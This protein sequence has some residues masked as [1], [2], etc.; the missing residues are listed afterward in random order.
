MRIF[1]LVLIVGVVGL[2]AAGFVWLQGGSTPPEARSLDTTTPEAVVRTFV[3]ALNSG[4]EDALILTLTGFQDVAETLRSAALD[5]ADFL[6]R[7]DLTA[8][9]KLSVLA[10]RD[11]FAAEDIATLPAI[12]LIQVHPDPRQSVF[13]IPGGAL[14]L[15]QDVRKT[16]LQ[17]AEASLYFGTQPHTLPLR[18]EETGWR[19][20]LS[21]VLSPPSLQP[22]DVEI[23]TRIAARGGTPGAWLNFYATVS[24]RSVDSSLLQLP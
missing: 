10:L 8:R 11:R 12:D 3:D 21:A 17:V 22:A 2:A 16:G 24:N 4:D 19:V 9:Q 14:V 13:A 15:I 5:D 7:D 18:Q 6:F 1:L 23:L 20:D